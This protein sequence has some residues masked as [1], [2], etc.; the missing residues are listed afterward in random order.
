MAGE[1]RA[2]DPR[3]T[4]RRVEGERRPLVRRRVLRQCFTK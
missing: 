2:A 4:I 1:H 3:Q